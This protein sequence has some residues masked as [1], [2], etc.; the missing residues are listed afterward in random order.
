MGYLR[1]HVASLPLKGLW[2]NTESRSKWKI[3]TNPAGLYSQ[4]YARTGMAA[5]SPRLQAPIDMHIAAKGHQSSI[6]RSRDYRY[7]DLH[8]I[9][10]TNVILPKVT[11]NEVEKYA[12]IYSTIHC[13]HLPQWGKFRTSTFPLLGI[14]N[15]W[16][17][18]PCRFYTANDG[19]G[20]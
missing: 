9:L 12:T 3:P 15:D 7:S 16:H 5:S 8:G 19:Y 20:I 1:L 18:A 4:P 10:Q 13:S 14:A 11:T 17:L 6:Q 2:P